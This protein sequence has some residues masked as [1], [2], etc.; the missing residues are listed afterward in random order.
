I[1]PQGGGLLTPRE[2]QVAVLAA[3]GR[4]DAQIAAELAISAR[5]VSTHLTSV[6]GKLGVSTRRD[7]PEAL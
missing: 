1:A 3:A 7:L 6:Y 4:T 2:Q 5:T